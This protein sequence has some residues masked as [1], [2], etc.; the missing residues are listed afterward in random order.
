MTADKIMEVINEMDNQKVINLWNECI[1]WTN[2][3]DDEVF[4]N[5]PSFFDTYFNSP[6]DAVLA[7]CYG[8]YKECKKYIAFDGYGN[9][10]TFDY[11][12]DYN[13]PVDIYILTDW[14]LENPEK[15]AEYGIDLDDNDDDDNEEE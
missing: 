15:A 2:R 4:E 10:V 14:L 11:W 8:K 6:S 7:A 1:E 3:S 9:V 12:D 5:D 13:S